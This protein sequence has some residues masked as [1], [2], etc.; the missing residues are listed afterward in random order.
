MKAGYDNVSSRRNSANAPKH[1]RQT[2][3]RIPGR[4]VGVIAVRPKGIKTHDFNPLIIRFVVNRYRKDFNQVV[5][6]T[7]RKT[8]LPRYEES[9]FNSCFKY[10]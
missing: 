2:D 5:D 7:D 9:L 3:R 10:W 8:K 4:L 6:Q 1:A